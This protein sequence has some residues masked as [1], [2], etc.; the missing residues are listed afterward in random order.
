MLLKF[1]TKCGLKQIKNIEKLSL[2][3]CNEKEYY[4]IN[5][6]IL[7]FLI[8]FFAEHDRFPNEGEIIK[9]KVSRTNIINVLGKDY[10]IGDLIIKPVLG[11][12]KNPNLLS[13]TNVVI[14][15]GQHRRSERKDWIIEIRKKLRSI[16]KTAFPDVGNVRHSLKNFFYLLEMY[17]CQKILKYHKAVDMQVK[18]YQGKG[19][20]ACSKEESIKIGEQHNWN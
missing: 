2:I 16:P 10:A 15:I 19:F 14:N 7:L 1:T 8:I 6:K 9:A 11:C 18:S 12:I 20:E 3:K 5:Y 4:K 17:R 13:L